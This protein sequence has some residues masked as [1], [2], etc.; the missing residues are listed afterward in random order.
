[1]KKSGIYSS[2]RAVNMSLQNHFQRS[3]L[4]IMTLQPSCIPSPL[5]EW[6]YMCKYNQDAVCF[7]AGIVTD[8]KS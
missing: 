1:M 4:G 2:F 7:T 6:Q 3:G 8:M 5:C